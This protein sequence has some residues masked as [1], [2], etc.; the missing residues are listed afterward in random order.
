MLLI[1]IGKWILHY[2]KRTGMQVSSV[3]CKLLTIFR[4]FLL[5]YHVFTSSTK[6]V[7]TLF[8]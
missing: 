7:L 4:V 8:T 1:Q 6:S 5:R 3:S 2:I